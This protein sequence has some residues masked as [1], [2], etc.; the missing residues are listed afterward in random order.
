[1]DSTVYLPRIQ[2]LIERPEE[3]SGF[4]FT[5]EESIWKRR[6]TQR[7]RAVLL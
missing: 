2:D 4:S 7:V 3:N 6:E 5:W 1:M